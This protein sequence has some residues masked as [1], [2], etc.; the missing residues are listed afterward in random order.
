[1]Q[2]SQTQNTAWSFG[3]TRYVTADHIELRTL[4]G[5]RKTPRLTLSACAQVTDFVDVVVGEP[6]V[7]VGNS[8]GSLAALHVA[9]T[10]PESTSGVVLINC[11]GGMNNKVKRMPGDFD[12]FGWQYKAVVPIFNVVLAVIDFVL[13][14]EP[15]A[16]PLFDNVRNEERY[17]IHNLV[18]MHSFDDSHVWILQR[19][20]RP[21]RRLQ[22]CFARGRR[23]RAVHMYGGEAGGCVWCVCQDFDRPS[24]YV[25]VL[26]PRKERTVV[27]V[28]AGEM[29]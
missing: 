1:L 14:I 18:Y 8:I 16:K 15:I 4:G 2:I 5:K 24:R 23:P 26:T 25:R 9:S 19:E 20:I 21:A 10:K 11:A 29:Y 6:A 28:R 22:G 12:G 7:L 27:C 17:V 13:K 3:E